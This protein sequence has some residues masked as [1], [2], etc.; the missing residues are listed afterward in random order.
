VEFVGE[1]AAGIDGLAAMSGAGR[2]AA[3]QDEAGDETV[4]DGAVVVVVVAQLQ[5]VAGRLRRLLAPELELEV[6]EVRLEEDLGAA[7][8]WSA[9][10]SGGSVQAETE[11][12]LGLG[13]ERVELRHFVGD[14]T[15]LGARVVCCFLFIYFI[16]ESVAS[17]RQRW[18]WEHAKRAIEPRVVLAAIIYVVTWISSYLHN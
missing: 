16:L 9:R 14:A 18:G 10:R 15:R 13:L 8:N 4:E 2:V 5:E 1:Q 17:M 12:V 6:A 11:N 7:F 3:L